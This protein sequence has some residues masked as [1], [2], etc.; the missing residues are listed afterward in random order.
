MRGG[1]FLRLA[2]NLHAQPS[3]VMAG[4]LRKDPGSASN[5]LHDRSL[6][7]MTLQAGVSEEVYETGCAADPV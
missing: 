1:S 5:S 3:R 4:H 7:A 6:L 2:H